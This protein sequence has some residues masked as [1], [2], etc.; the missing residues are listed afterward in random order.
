MSLFCNNDFL[1]D[2]VS[3]GGGYLYEINTSFISICVY[4]YI[5]I[6]DI[7]HIDFLTYSVVD[8]NIYHI[9]S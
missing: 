9:N 4:L 5:V 7:D 1:D 3:I 6:I 8:L 2:D